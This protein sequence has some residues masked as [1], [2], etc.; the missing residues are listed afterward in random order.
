MRLVCGQTEADGRVDSCNLEQAE[1]NIYHSIPR[2]VVYVSNREAVHAPPHLCAASV[3]A[4]RRRWSLMT[5]QS[6]VCILLGE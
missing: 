6:Y 4:T 1:A 5:S 3:S 2:L